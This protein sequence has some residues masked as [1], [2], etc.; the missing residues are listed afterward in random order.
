[1]KAAP[2][3]TP[4]PY[5]SKNSTIILRDFF[6]DIKKQKNGTSKQMIMYVSQVKFRGRFQSNTS[7]VTVLMLAD[8][9]YSLVKNAHRPNNSTATNDLLLNLDKPQTPSCTIPPCMKATPRPTNNPATTS[10]PGSVCSMNFFLSNGQKL[11]VWSLYSVFR[12]AE[13]K[14]RP[15]NKVI[16]FAFF[17]P[18]ITTIMSTK[19]S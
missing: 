19:V 9:L 12:K 5:S 3:A 14:T 1:M 6:S 11:I 15:I 2:A 7:S 8:S 10:I 17:G 16:F 13:L 18:T 4:N